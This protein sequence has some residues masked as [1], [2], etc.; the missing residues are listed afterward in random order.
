[1]IDPERL[2][3]EIDILETYAECAVRHRLTIEAWRGAVQKADK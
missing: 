1:L 2:Q 3:W